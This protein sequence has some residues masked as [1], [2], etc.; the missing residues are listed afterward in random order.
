[1]VPCHRRDVQVLQVTYIGVAA[2]VHGILAE[3]VQE[4]V[5]RGMCRLLRDLLLVILR[6]GI[7]VVLGRLAARLLL[8]PLLLHKHVECFVL[9]FLVVHIPDGKGDSRWGLGN[10]TIQ[11]HSLSL[12]G[13]EG[14][15]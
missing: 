8:L 13:I 12:V 5:I 1:M 2:I 6:I 4:C 14:T 15:W 9:V 7:S 3:P 10:L 11:R